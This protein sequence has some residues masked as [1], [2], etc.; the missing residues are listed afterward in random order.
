MR[1]V[2][3]HKMCGLVGPDGHTFDDDDDENTN[4]PII[5][6]EAELEED[7]PQEAPLCC[8]QEPRKALTNLSPC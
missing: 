1:C 8:S 4:K 5:K 7:E 3:D 6:P 2:K